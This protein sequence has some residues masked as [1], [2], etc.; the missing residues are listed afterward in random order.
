[1]NA[2]YIIFVQVSLMLSW[3]FQVFF[4]LEL[5]GGSITELCIKE[6][7]AFSVT[8]VKDLRDDV[9]L[10]DTV[11]VTGTTDPGDPHVILPS[12]TS[13]TIRWK[14]AHPGK[15]FV[16]KCRPKQPLQSEAQ[17]LLTEARGEPDVP[18]ELVIGASGRRED[19][20]AATVKF[21]PTSSQQV[22][23]IVPCQVT[24]QRYIARQGLIAVLSVGTALFRAM[25]THC[26]DCS[27]KTAALHCYPGV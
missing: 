14:D 2:T 10:G 21:E 19:S 18:A 24:L 20:H 9:K 7:P 16:P 6:G 23:E 12:S 11:L 27:T 3:L 5:E 15:H 13:V 8:R 4:D 1:V 25:L 17:E 22:T 26:R